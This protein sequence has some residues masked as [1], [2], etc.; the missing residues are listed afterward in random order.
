M[1][2]LSVKKIFPAYC[3]SFYFIPLSLFEP[4]E[5]GIIF[6]PLL[7]PKCIVQKLFKKVE[8]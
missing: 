4:H 6:L 8:F 3:I 1:Y 5:H 7:E 2:K